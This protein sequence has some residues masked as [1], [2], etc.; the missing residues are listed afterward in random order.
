M[1]EGKYLSPSLTTTMKSLMNLTAILWAKCIKEAH[2]Q[3][4][5]GY[6]CWPVGGGP[7]LLLGTSDASEVYGEGS[8][9]ICEDW[10]ESYMYVLFLVSK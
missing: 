6:P 4:R 9:I 7:K 1:E 3:S 5:R 10:S 2:S 8:K